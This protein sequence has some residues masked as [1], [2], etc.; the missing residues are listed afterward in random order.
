MTWKI[1][2]I[3]DGGQYQLVAKMGVDFLKPDVDDNY[4]RMAVVP[5]H[6][7]LRNIGVGHTP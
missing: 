3:D 7:V 2:T 1:V 5:S 4:W 6:E